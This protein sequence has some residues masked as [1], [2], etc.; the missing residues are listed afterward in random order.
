[1]CEWFQGGMAAQNGD[2]FAVCDITTNPHL[3]GAAIAS[4]STAIRASGRSDGARLGAMGIFFDWAPQ[5]AAIIEGVGLSGDE[6]EMA[7]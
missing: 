5:A 6:R 4:H 3:G 1:M 7:G 2:D